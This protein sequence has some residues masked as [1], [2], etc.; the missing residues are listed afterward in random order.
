MLIMLTVVVLMHHTVEYC[1]VIILYHGSVY[2]VARET[3]YK[4]M[5]MA[6]LGVSELRNH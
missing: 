6:K 4:P 2:T 5:G 1:P 3:S